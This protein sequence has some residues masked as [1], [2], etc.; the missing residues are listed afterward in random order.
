MK[1]KEIKNREKER[2]E[3]KEFRLPRRLRR[4]LKVYSSPS[5]H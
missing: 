5:L 2:K 3:K 1:K 4:K